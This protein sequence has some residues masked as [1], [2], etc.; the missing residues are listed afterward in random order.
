MVRSIRR[1]RV[2]YGMLILLVLILGLTSRHFV[3]YLPKFLGSYIGDSLWA[4]MIFFIIGFIY[5][6]LNSSQVALLAIAFSFAIEAS[7]L[8]HAP[9][10]DGIRQT[11]IGGLVLG[12]TF[13]WS[14]LVDHSEK[15]DFGVAQECG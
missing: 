14:D 15:K 8:Y 9:W 13:V 11:F 4:L 12:Y 7:Q 6:T 1:K 10:I 5:K 2:I 3:D